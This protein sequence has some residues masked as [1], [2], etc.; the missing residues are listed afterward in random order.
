MAT[1][2]RLVTR[3]SEPRKAAA[4][5]HRKPTRPARWMLGP[6]GGSQTGRDGARRGRRWP[7]CAQITLLCKVMSS[8]LAVHHVQSD[9]AQGWVLEGA[10]DRPYDPEAQPLVELDGRG[11]RLGDRVE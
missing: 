3:P 1:S 9:P 4:P 2:N 7:P 11:V 10:G 5:R 8:E 6:R